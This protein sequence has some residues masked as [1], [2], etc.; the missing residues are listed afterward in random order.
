MSFKI[1]KANLVEIG[2]ILTSVYGVLSSTAVL[3]KLP[4]SISSILTIVGPVVI[5]LFAYLNHPSTGTTTV[6]VVSANG[7]TVNAP[8]AP[9]QVIP[10]SVNSTG[11]VA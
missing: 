5:S 9:V 3:N 10:P 7:V 8:V 11:Q 2:A 6:P 1:T 4:L